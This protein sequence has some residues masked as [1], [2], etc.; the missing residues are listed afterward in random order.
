MTTFNI[1]ALL[2]TLA[3]VFSF[4]NHRYIGLPNAV[5]VM[6]IALLMSLGIVALDGLG[7]DYEEQAR[8]LL[9]HIDF[10]RTVLHGLLSFMLFAGALNI[11]SKDLVK[12]K[13]GISQ[14][15]TIGILSSTLI[16]GLLLWSAMQL[17]NIDLPLI[18][19]LLFGALISPTDAVVVLS[20]LRSMRISKRLETR[21][22]GESLFNDGVALVVFLALLGLATGRT[23]AS[24]HELLKLFAL[25]AIG[26]LIFGWAAGWLGY[27]MLKSNDN[28][29]ID[30]LITLALVMGG[31]ALADALHV[32]APIAIATAGLV[33]GNHG[34][35]RAMSPVSRERLEAFWELI[36]EIL[37]AVLFV[38]IGMEVLALTFTHDH[39]LAGLV[40]IPIVL[41]AR[42]TSVSLPTLLVGS[43][44]GYTAYEVKILTWA[45]LRG[46]VSIALALS[47]PTGPYRD[48]I[49]AATYA[50]V[51]FSILIQAPTIKHMIP[52]Q[53]PT[54]APDGP[55][56]H[57]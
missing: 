9:Q 5:G 1:L 2:I 21:I 56:S 57:P 7:L 36:D 47:L 35:Q 43:K 29:Q 31:Y 3:A 48:L 53:L 17:L 4:L 39:L 46:A 22:A 19:C 30:V 52:S 11:S 15:A 54:Y 50:V 42:F 14:L 24:P 16:V 25:E 49:V 12:E 34:R 40:A 38:L 28:Y 44:R 8:T 18:Y 51:V 33:I 27:V 23:D 20:V 32:S 13:W 6:L 37:G 26:G 10:N 41:L 45:G 55:S